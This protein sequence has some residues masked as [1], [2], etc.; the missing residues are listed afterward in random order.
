MLKLRTSPARAFVRMLRDTRA[1]AAVEFAMIA[2]ILLLMFFATIELTNA[3]DCRA[4]VNNATSTSADLVA[5]ATTVTK[6][7]L[8]NIAAAAGTI[9]YPFKSSAAKVVISSV[10]DN[11]TS[12]DDTSYGTVAWSYASNAT[13]R[14][15][16][17]VVSMPGGLITKG[18]GQSVIFAEIT[19]AYTPPTTEFI[20]GTVNMQG[21]FY[22]RPRRAT[23]IT[24]SDCN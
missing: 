8:A 11:N 15:V 3:L 20:V 12:T 1:I 14:S 13:A 24:C 23:T 18:S 21:V 22:S 5:Q 4:R 16:G 9:L 19:Y 10:V 2:P 6:S 7:D 17:A